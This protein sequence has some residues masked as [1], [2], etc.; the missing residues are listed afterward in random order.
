MVSNHWQI[1]GTGGPWNALGSLPNIDIAIPAGATL[2]R[3][4]AFDHQFNAI[5]TGL[6][7]NVV[8]NFS[9]LQ[10]VTIVGGPDNGHTLWQSI[11][12]LTSNVV[13]LNDVTTIQRVYTQYV[14]AGDDTLMINERT[15]FG[16]RT[17]PGFT[18]RYAVATFVGPNFAGALSYSSYNY[19]FKALYETVP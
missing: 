15:A 16:K 7:F 14:N 1:Q 19:A 10:Q 4:V 12:P 13:A 6:A 8:G 3:F 5:Q 2:K 9:I 11:H 17:G 18:L